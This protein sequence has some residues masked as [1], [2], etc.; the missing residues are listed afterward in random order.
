V[1]L[2]SAKIADL[3]AKHLEMIQAVILRMSHQA[4][5]IKNYCITVSAAVCGFAVTLQR[6]IVALVA[7]LPIASFALLEAHYLRLERCFR[8]LFDH[9]R[10]EPW[11]K[12]P[13]FEI[14]LKTVPPQRYWTALLSWS[15]TGFYLP[16]AAGVGIV[17]IIARCIYG[18][19]I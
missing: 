14:S 5:A 17:A 11:E 3:K 8:A 4:A 10:A 9:T 19:F 15:I 18:K 6:P 2:D 12:V 13:T 16:L 7:L 1:A